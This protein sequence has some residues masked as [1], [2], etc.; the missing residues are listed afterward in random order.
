MIFTALL[1]NP[2]E[3]SVSTYL[4][5]EYAKIADLEYTH[6]KLNVPAEVDLPVYLHSLHKIGCAG[7]NITLPYKLAVVKY[8][9]AQDDRAQ[10]IGAVNTVVMGNSGLI[11]YNTDGVG[12]YRSISDHLRPVK[13]G[14]RVTVLGSGGAARAIIYELY[15]RTDEI[16]VLGQIPAQL[17]SLSKDFHNPDRKPLQVSLIRDAAL[18]DCLRTADFLINATPV[19]MYPETNDSLVTPALLDRLEQERSMKDLWTFDAVFNPHTTLMLKLLAQ[20][21]SPTCSGIWM[22]IY[23]AVEAFALWT[24]K[25]VSQAPFRDIE[26]KLQHLLEQR[27]SHG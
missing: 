17:E 7:V 16:T 6:I 23:Q 10:A 13:S 18:Y 12:A 26:A 19:G 1:G 21:G 3:H 5:S 15:Q 25:D 11:G 2:V 20:R 27:Y 4:F 8:L 14:D 22:M 24:G 9:D